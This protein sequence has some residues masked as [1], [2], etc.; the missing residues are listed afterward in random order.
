MSQDKKVR[1]I[2]VNGRVVPIKDKDPSAAQRKKNYKKEGDGA[3]Q[4]SN[5]EAKYAAKGYN[6]SKAAKA[7]GFAGVAGVG[8]S[9]LTNGKK[10]AIGLGVGIAS[11]VGSSIA[12][13]RNQKKYDVQK[14]R[15]YVRKFGMTSEGK[16]PKKTKTG[17]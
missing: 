14:E 17:V 12:A 8:Y 11:I 15:E 6:T 5:I 1:F 16:K 3:R 13:K 10:S 2:R 7:L 9:L 4:A